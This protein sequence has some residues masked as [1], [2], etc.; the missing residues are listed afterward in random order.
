MR[1]RRRKALTAKPSP[2]RAS[3][4]SD[5][6]DPTGF[7]D[8]GHFAF[9]KTENTVTC[10]SHGH[11]LKHTPCRR[12]PPYI[13]TFRTRGPRVSCLMLAC[14]CSLLELVHRI[15]VCSVVILVRVS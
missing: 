7:C 4:L 5:P 15:H 13:S 10:L 1:S 11:K 14:A 3:E 12:Y 2:F 9:K 6:I 8:D